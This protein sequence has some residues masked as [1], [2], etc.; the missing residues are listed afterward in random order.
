MQMSGRSLPGTLSLIMSALGHMHATHR[1]DDTSAISDC[2][3]ASLHAPRQGTHLT[4]ARCRRSTAGGESAGRE[5]GTG[6]ARRRGIYVVVAATGVK[7]V[8]EKGSKVPNLSIKSL[9]IAVEIVLHA[10][11]EWTELDGWRPAKVRRRRA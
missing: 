11:F 9:S 1:I 8:G 6:V 3:L 2:S 10:E 7:V 5:A 4:R